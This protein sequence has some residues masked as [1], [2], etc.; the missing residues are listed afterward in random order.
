[1]FVEILSIGDAPVARDDSPDR[2]RH[3]GHSRSEIER[4]RCRRRSFGGRIR[5]QSFTWRRGFKRRWDHHL[6]PEA[7]LLRIGRLEL[8]DHRRAGGRAS[9]RVAVVIN[10][11]QDAP[12]ARDDFA[13][14]IWPAPITIDVLVN[15]EFFDGLASVEIVTQPQF[16][17]AGHQ[18]R[19]HHYLRAAHLPAIREIR[20]CDC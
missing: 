17:R 16:G 15:D 9:A 10:A 7:Q 19:F 2:R 14:T 5:D 18:S 4:L 13:E 11:V 1:M 12:V 20:L 8:R 6:H 3:R